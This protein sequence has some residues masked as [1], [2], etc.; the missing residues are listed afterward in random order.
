MVGG[1]T[2]LT[3]V[4]EAYAVKPGDCV[5]VHA[6][7]GG[8]GLLLGQLL[9]DLGAHSIGTVST[10]AKAKLAAEAGYEHVIQSYDPEIVIPKI[11]ELTSGAGVICVYDGVVPSPVAL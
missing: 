1:I 3:L 6:A 4:R 10:P 7:A 5:L 8:T 11:K 2:V 9:K